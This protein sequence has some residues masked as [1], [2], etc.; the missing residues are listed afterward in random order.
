MGRRAG[1]RGAGGVLGMKLFKPS[2][3]E[4]SLLQGDRVEL[5]SGARQSEAASV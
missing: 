5:R 1:E 2:T 4:A 3:Q